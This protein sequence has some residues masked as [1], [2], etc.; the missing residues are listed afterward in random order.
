[1]LQAIIAVAAALVVGFY[2]GL[3][4]KRAQCW[5]PQCGTSLGCLICEGGEK[6]TGVSRSLNERS[7][8]G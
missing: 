7:Y 4:I 6:W 2:T 8:P 5:C 3:L 1:M